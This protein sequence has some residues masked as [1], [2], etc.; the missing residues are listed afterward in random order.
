MLHV[1]ERA[2]GMP[3]IC[4]ALSSREV[5]A[6]NGYRRRGMFVPHV[7]CDAMR[8]FG[9]R[10]HEVAPSLSNRVDKPV[11]N[12][13]GIR[14]RFRHA[15]VVY[16]ILE[17]IETE[18][19]GRWGKPIEGGREGVWAEVGQVFYFKLRWANGPTACQ[20]EVVSVIDS[21]ISLIIGLRPG[22]PDPPNPCFD[23]PRATPGCSKGR[24]LQLFRRPKSTSK[25]YR[26][27]ESSKIHQNDTLNRSW[28]VQGSLFDK[29]PNMTLGIPFGIDLFLLR[30][31]ESVQ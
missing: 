12:T 8:K 9:D 1:K 22:T 15:L 13:F 20:N 14:G 19:G 10:S 25:Y 18:L 21:S 16:V 30:K 28:C 6:S 2:H 26:F 29:K 7:P 31:L 24:T 3:C 5:G 27:F 17:H 4:G 11:S 23:V